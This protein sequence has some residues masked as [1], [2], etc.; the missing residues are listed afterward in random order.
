M[1]VLCVCTLAPLLDPKVIRQFNT[2]LNVSVVLAVENSNYKGQK[3]II[4]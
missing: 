4:P 1:V 3:T 2:Y